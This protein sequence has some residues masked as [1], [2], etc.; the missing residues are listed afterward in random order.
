VLAVVA[1]ILACVGLYGVVAH[2]VAQR[3]REF[4]I[5]AALGAS[6]GDMWRLVLRQAAAIVGG[7]VAV[8]LIGAYAFAQV[9]SSRLVGVTPLDPLLWSAAVALLVVVALA[10][11]LKP[12]LTA[13][14]VEISE[15]LRAL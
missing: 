2:G 3:R 4:G 6:R 8:G 9:L 15:T 10:A 11:S 13:S 1:A 7:G 14:R 5:R 12:A